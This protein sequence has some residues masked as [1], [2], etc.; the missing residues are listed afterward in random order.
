MGQG[1]MMAKQAGLDVESIL[2]IKD[3]LRDLASDYGLT[4]QDK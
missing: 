3:V 4:I 2:P 1:I